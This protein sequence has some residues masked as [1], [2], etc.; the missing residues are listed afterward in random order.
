MVTTRCS[1]FPKK[2]LFAGMFEPR[3]GLT[4]KNLQKG[5]FWVRLPCVGFERLRIWL[6]RKVSVPERMLCRWGGHHSVLALG[7]VTSWVRSRFPSWGPADA[8]TEGEAESIGWGCCFEPRTDHRKSPAEGFTNGRQFVSPWQARVRPA[9]ARSV[10][11]ES[12]AREWRG[13]QR[14]I[15]GNQRLGREAQK[16]PSSEE[17]CRRRS[18][19]SDLGS[20]EP[21]RARSGLAL[22]R[23]DCRWGGCQTRCCSGEEM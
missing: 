9:T 10:P 5:F 3:M 11:S 18:T 16:R 8:R 20:R 1:R 2:C 4:V 6:E 14:Q 22:S 17:V 23:V 12:L 15:P 13:P 19:W 21:I 7:T